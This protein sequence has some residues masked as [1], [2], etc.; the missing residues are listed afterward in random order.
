MYSAAPLKTARSRFS[1]KSPIQRDMNSRPSIVERAYQLARSGRYATV[2]EI[3]TQ[4][5]AENYEGAASC[6]RGTSLVNQLRVIM[7]ALSRA[8]A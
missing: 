2:D 1:E 3:R 8:Q 6:I 5:S 4:L 7:G